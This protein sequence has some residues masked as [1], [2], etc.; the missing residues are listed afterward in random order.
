M[1]SGFFVLWHLKTMRFTPRKKGKWLLLH[2]FLRTLDYVHGLTPASTS[3][4]DRKSSPEERG[5]SQQSS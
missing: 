4:S 3:L 5:V 1:V 2:W